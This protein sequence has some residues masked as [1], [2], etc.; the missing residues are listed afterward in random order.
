GLPLRRATPWAGLA[1]SASRSPPTAGS[2]CPVASSSSRGAPSSCSA[3]VGSSEPVMPC[4]IFL[5][6]TTPC[7]RDSA[8][9]M[10]R[11]PAPLSSSP[12]A[13]RARALFAIAEALALAVVVLQTPGLASATTTLGYDDA[14]HL[15]AR[16][17]FG[18]T[19]AEV[20]AYAGMTRDAA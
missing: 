1:G 12:V 6:D 14:R 9:R 5:R 15:L 2:A 11:S 3:R 17:G 13:K 7:S 16:T 8:L 19:D 18:P 20:S 10:N 4:Y